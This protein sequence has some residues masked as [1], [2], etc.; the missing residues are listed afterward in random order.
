[1][2]LKDIDMEKTRQQSKELKRMFNEK[3]Y[4]D[5]QRVLAKQEELRANPFSGLSPGRPLGLFGNFAV[6]ASTLVVLA[7]L[8]FGGF[9]LIVSILGLF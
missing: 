2:N 8:V 1:M 3:E 4:Q 9:A 6:I 5:L 7:I